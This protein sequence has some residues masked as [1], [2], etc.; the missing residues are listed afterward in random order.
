MHAGTELM[1]E[2]K[3]VLATILKKHRAFANNLRLFIDSKRRVLPAG[4]VLTGG[5]GQLS[6]LEE[7]IRDF[8]R[9]PTIRAVLP[10]AFGSN[11][12]H[13]DTSLTP[14]LGAAVYGSLAQ[15][16]PGYR[17]STFSTVFKKAWKWS[18]EVLKSLLP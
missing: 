9:L 18:M 15:R 14:A 4:I 5:G 13:H 2:K 11:K 17:T 16:D 7:H 6:L 10:K 3:K 1:K 8:M 12:K